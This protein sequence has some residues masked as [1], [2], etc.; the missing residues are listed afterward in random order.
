MSLTIVLPG[1]AI[2]LFFI[3]FFYSGSKRSSYLSFVL[4]FLPL[5]DHW[6]TPAAFGPITVFHFL[7]IIAFFI[8]YKDFIYFSKANRGYIIMFIIFIVILV[9]GSLASQ[10]VVPSLFGILTII[11]AFIYSRLLIL[12]ITN[13]PVFLK[14]VIVL[15]KVGCLIGLVFIVGQ[16]IF[17]LKFTFYSALNQNTIDG[18]KIRYPAFFADSQLSGLYLA[19]CSFFFL[20]N[21]ED[22]KSPTWKN[23]IFFG[24][25]AFGVLLAGSRSGVLGLV[26]GIMFLMIFVGGK[27]R[28]YGVLCTI[29]LGTG[30]LFFSDSIVVFKRFDDVDDS[31][32]FRSSIWGKGL[33]VFDNNF[34]LG[35]GMNNYFE[36]VKLHSQDQYLM[37][38]N[39]EI[40]FLSAPEN[41]YI[42]LM[43]EFGFFAFLFFISFIVFPVINVVHKFLKG[44]K[45]RISF[46]LIAPII[47]WAVSSI[48]FYNLGDTRIV[49]LFSTCIAILIAYPSDPKREIFHIND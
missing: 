43:A 48:T 35:I 49:I 40:M 4:L 23:Y 46:F 30:L 12:E 41:G 31:V 21:I 17:G 26:L 42:K 11:P 10:F 13:D 1:L 36:Y 39:D 29:V 33:E 2:I 22:L 28:F 5:M 20:V 18:T 34:T 15:V 24:V 9:M 37:V 27:F 32:N 6:I 25:V 38:D 8:F 14:K 7:T 44:K 16:M 19:M 45:T 3:Y 47:C